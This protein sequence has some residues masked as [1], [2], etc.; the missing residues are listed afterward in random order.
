MSTAALTASELAECRATAEESL[1]D[2]ATIQHRTSAQSG[3]GGQTWTWNDVLEV[4]CRLSPIAGGEGTSTDL[5]GPKR[6]K[7]ETTH[8]LSIP[9]DTLIREIDRVRCDGQS[10]EVTY[11][12]S[13]TTWEILRRVELKEMV[14]S[15]Q[16]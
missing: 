16:P 13:R 9:H 11:V 12:R 10:Y 6:V 2:T 8:V 3:G 7:Q 4:P 1:P 14:V 5:S 15:P